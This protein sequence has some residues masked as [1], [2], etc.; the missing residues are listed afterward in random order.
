MKIKYTI[1][2]RGKSFKDPV[3]PFLKDNFTNVAFNQIDSLFGF[4]EPCTLYGGRVFEQPQL[5][6]NDLFELSV[7][8]IGLRLPLTNHTVSEEEYGGYADFLAKYHVEG[9]SAIVTNDKLAR[10]LRRDF[11]KFKIESSVIKNTDTY[12]KIDQALK[13]YDTVVLPMKLNEDLQFLSGIESKEQITLFAN[14]GCALNCPSKICY[15]SISQINKNEPGAKFKCSKTTK[16]REILG[17]VDFDLEPL[18]GL[19]FRRFKLLR[20]MPLGI[21]GY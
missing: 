21:T 8:G 14:A 3:I 4:V 16:E 5:S 9:N 15:G 13:L 18:V 10:W 2:A 20:A 12:A 19:G 11:P 6:G 1:S 7:Y 17:M